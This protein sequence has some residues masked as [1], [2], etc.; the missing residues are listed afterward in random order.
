MRTQLTDCE[1]YSEA[2]GLFSARKAIMQY[3]QLKGI[4]NVSMDG[5]YTGNGVSELIQLCMN[6][7]LN[8][9][10]EILIP[11]PTTRCGPPAPR[12][13]EHAI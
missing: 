5:I 11:C 1:G 10:D 6:A 4:P 3:A 2:R 9:G 12:S 13:P 8:N 7:L